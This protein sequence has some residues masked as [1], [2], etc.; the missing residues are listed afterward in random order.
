MASRILFRGIITRFVVFQ[1]DINYVSLP[2]HNFVKFDRIPFNAKL[3]YI[4]L[5]FLK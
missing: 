2:Y 3:N 5:E 4:K 1:R